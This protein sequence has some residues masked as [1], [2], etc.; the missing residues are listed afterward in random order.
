MRENNKKKISLLAL[1]LT[2]M[3]LIISL[4]FAIK[5]EFKFKKI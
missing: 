2:A 5:Q 3:S 4:E 1:T